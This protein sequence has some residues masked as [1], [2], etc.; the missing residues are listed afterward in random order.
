MQ[1]GRHIVP[2]ATRQCDSTTLAS[3]RRYDDHVTLLYGGYI[4]A[5]QSQCRSRSSAITASPA[6][7]HHHSHSIVVVAIAASRA[8]PC[9]TCFFAARCNLVRSFLSSF[10]C[11]LA[12]FACEVHGERTG[13]EQQPQARPTKLRVTSARANVAAADRESSITPDPVVRIR[14]RSAG[15]LTK[16]ATARSICRH[17]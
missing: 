17:G 16:V 11:F 2:S 8:L 1:W 14:H 9:R 3:C 4:R 5:S 7:L 12:A 10:F 6:S 15:V 13:Q